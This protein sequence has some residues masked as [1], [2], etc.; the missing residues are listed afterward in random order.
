MTFVSLL[1]NTM[2]SLPFLYVPLL[3]RV[4]IM[5]P[6]LTQLGNDFVAMAELFMIYLMNPDVNIF[7]LI[8]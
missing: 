5:P 8:F 7:I 6:I 3:E 2:G 1:I 4:F